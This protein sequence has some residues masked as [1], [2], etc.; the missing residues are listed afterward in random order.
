MLNP[1][2]RS[3]YQGYM[4][5]NQSVMEEGDESSEEE[6][7]EVADSHKEEEGVEVAN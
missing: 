2:G 3:N 5:A 7:V 4:Q 6:D 1:G